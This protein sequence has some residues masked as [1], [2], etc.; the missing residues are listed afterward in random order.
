M[1]R[2]LH[3][4]IRPF[5]HGVATAFSNDGKWLASVDP[6]HPANPFLIRAGIADERIINWHNDSNNIF[7]ARN[8]GPN[9][10][11]TNL[12]LSSGRRT[13]WVTF[14]PPDKT[15]LTPNTFLLITPDG[16]HF[17]YEAHK[18]F[19]TLFIADRVQ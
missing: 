18:I 13:P 16:A 4:A 1:C 6:A 3:Y 17:S 19:S 14:S 15:A 7:L 9:V 11:V 12:E 8:D 10:Q 5:R 2:K